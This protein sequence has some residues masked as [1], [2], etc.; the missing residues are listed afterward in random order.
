MNLLQIRAKFAFVVAVS[1]LFSCS[2]NSTTTATK[3][4][5]LSIEGTWQLLQGTLTE[6][7]KATVTDYT[8]DQKFIKIINGDH[9][10]F[11]DHDLTKGKQPKPIF[12]SGG[13]K[14]TLNGD[15][16]TEYLEYCNEREWENNKFDFT[17]TIKNDTLTQKG[18]EKIDSLGVNRVNVEKYV[19]VKAE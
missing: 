9:F 2:N 7:G 13:G 3:D 11:M 8:K 1:M 4:Q 12:S 14:Y 6:K 15:K 10:S 19:R 16:Y 5:K 18:I 17:I